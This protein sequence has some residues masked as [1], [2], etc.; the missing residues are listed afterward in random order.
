[1]TRPIVER[2]LAAGAWGVTV[3]TVRQASVALGWGV[4]RIVIANQV[5]HRHDLAAIRSWLDELPDLELYCFADSVAGI[6]AAGAALAGARRGLRVLVDVGTPGGRTGIRDAADG[7]VLATA[8]RGSDG[9]LLAGV[10]G[11]E[12]VRP[13]RRDAETTALVDAHCRATVAVLRCQVERGSSRPQRFA[14]S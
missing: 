13:N 1:M 8:C 9:L 10:A 5:V 6:Q 3:A 4:R 2:Q 11:Y 7:D 12:G 14:S